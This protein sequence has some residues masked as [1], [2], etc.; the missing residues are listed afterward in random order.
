MRK[1]RISAQSSRAL[2][3]K[4]SNKGMKYQRKE[5]NKGTKGTVRAPED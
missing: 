4:V 3:S 5:L 1:R 2:I